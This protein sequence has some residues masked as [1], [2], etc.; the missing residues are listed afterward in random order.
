MTCVGGVPRGT[1]ATLYNHLRLSLSLLDDET[2]QEPLREVARAW[3]ASVL[4]FLG[5]ERSLTDALAVVQRAIVRGDEESAC[6]V[7]SAAAGRLPPGG[8]ALIRLG[9]QACAARRP[10]VL[11]VVASEIRRRGLPVPDSWGQALVED[12]GRDWSHADGHRQPEIADAGGRPSADRSAPSTRSPDAII[13]SR[14]VLDP[15]G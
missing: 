9:D 10:R 4:E 13:V 15:E 7:L 6:R 2:A 8:E 12:P 1:L 14:I 11:D 5:D 3:A